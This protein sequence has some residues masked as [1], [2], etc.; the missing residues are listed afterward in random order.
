MGLSG[1]GSEISNTGTPWQKQCIWCLCLQAEKLLGKFYSVYNVPTTTLW[2]LH[3]AI[4]KRMK[5]R[6][7][8]CTGNIINH[9]DS[10]T[11][12]TH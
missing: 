9:V 5:C 11:L 10:T 7:A 8:V 1:L 4:R 2:S 6:K 3:L 12:K